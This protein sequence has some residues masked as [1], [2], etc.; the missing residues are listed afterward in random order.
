MKTLKE[1]KVIAG[2]RDGLYV[3]FSPDM[4]GVEAIGLT[5]QDAV[6]DIQKKLQALFGSK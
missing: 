3:A 1:F 2:K 4:P 5:E 6:R